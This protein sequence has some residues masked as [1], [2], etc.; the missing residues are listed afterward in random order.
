MYYHKNIEGQY[1]V[2]AFLVYN[3]STTTIHDQLLPMSL[4]LPQQQQCDDDDCL[5]IIYMSDNE[6]EQTVEGKHEIN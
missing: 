4:P 2:T 5:Q 6:N 3:M 1:L